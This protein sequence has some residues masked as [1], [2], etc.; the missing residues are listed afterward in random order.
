MPLLAVLSLLCAAPPASAAPTNLQVLPKTTPRSEVIATMRTF[1]FALGVRCLECHVGKEGDPASF[2]YASDEKGPKKTA[3]QMMR[4]VAAINKDYLAKRPAPVVSVQCVTCHHGLRRP[5]TLQD[6]LQ[7]ELDHK[8]LDAAVALYGELRGKYYGGGQYDFSETSLN[9]LAES[10]GR[11]EK[12]REAA[13][14]MELNAKNATLTGWGWNLLGMAHRANG[15][16]DKA[17]ADFEKI[18]A[19]NPDD[20]WAKD[21]LKELKSA[22]Q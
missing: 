22:K 17:I 21:Q 8:G 16:T 9:L 1:S 2:D 12:T 18:V 19:A 10:L 11:Q 14:V 3:R 4:M 20:G 7:E 5:K 6:T 13:A 15:E